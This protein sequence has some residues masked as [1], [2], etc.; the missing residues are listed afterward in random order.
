MTPFAAET[1]AAR[2]AQIAWANTSIKE[3]LGPVGEFRRLL[4]ERL[5]DITAAIQ[6]DVN[7]PPD[8]VVSSEVLPV[9]DA[10]RFLE[11]HAT[12][13]LKPRVLNW[14]PMWLMGCTDLVYRRPWGVVAVIG[15]WNYPLFLNAVPVLHALTAGNAV[16][17]EANGRSV[18]QLARAENSVLGG[19]LALRSQAS[20]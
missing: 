14:R 4:V 9:A 12:R 20:L 17:E 2:A 5:N 16:L 10:A 13:I 3:R 7:R 8:Q 18:E 11:Q 19:L 15:T 6:A 1:A